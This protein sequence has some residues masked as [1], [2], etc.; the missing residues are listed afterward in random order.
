MGKARDL[1]R[2]I[3]DKAAATGKAKVNTESKSLLACQASIDGHKA[4]NAET[5]RAMMRVA[6][7]FADE[8]AA[9]RTEAAA[10]LATL[11]GRL[12]ELQAQVRAVAVA[13]DVW[14]RSLRLGC[15]RAIRKAA[16]KRDEPQSTRPALNWRLH[17]K[18]LM[19]PFPW[20][21]RNGCWASSKRF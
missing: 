3:Y 9:S 1:G 2:S 18:P 20:A 4:A 12:A 8:A 10:H 15:S 14:D 5:R 13:A 19:C 21:K 17:A 7:S 6:R 11:K 16:C